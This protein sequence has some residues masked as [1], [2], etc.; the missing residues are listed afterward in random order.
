MI[1]SLV[2]LFIPIIVVVLVAIIIVAC[3]ERFSPDAFITTIVRWVVFAAVLIF[4]LQK[5]LP[6]L[7][8]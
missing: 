7:G 3:A 5:L 1:S 4:L 8:V 6:L 2:A